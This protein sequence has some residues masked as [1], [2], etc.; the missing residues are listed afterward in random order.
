[1]A[2]F[3]EACTA[4]VVRHGRPFVVA[5]FGEVGRTTAQIL[6]GA[7]EPVIVV[8]RAGGEGVDVTGDVLDASVLEACGIGDARAAI[9]AL[10]SDSTTVFAT[11]LI[12]E[13]APHLPILARVERIET[14]ARVRRAG[15]DFAISIAQVSAQLLAARLLGREALLVAPELQVR[16]VSGE[17]LVGR[18]PAELAIRERTGASIVAIERGDEVITALE[19]GF[20]FVEGD[21]VFVC[22][23]EAAIEAF[24]ATFPAGGPKAAPRAVATEEAV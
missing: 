24:A 17:G 22:G 3:G 10:D 7:G 14:I 12:R 16:R 6:R 9:L 8:D 20:E 1:V 13:R 2:R 15:A 21:L 18:H 4:G 5:G 23:G 19:P 11:L